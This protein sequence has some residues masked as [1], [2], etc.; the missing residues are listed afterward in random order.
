MEQPPAMPPTPATP[1]VK[2][3]LPAIV[4]VGIGCGG[5]LLIAIIVG[6]VLVSF[7]GVKFK[8]FADNP[9]K[10]AAEMI[11]SA[12]PDLEKVSQDNEKGEMTIKTKDGREITLSYQDLAEGKIS[13]TDAEGDTTRIG[14]ADLS[15]V[16][17]WVPKAPDLSDAVSTFHREGGGQVTGQFS[18]KCGQSLEQ[19]REFFEGEASSLGLNTS[20]NSSMNAN[21]TAVVTLSF[22]GG[23]KS[24]TVVITEKPG[25]QILV[26]TNYS[27]KK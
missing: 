15:Q 4:W 13:V 9:E 8:E 2:K 18:G 26:N 11:V 10:T 24:L 17:A 25:S 16:P 22:S 21:G 27:E 3:G 6:A 20:S 14:S 1:P 12:N 7:L 19:I 23:D 5:L